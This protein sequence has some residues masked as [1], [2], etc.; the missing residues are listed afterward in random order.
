M[1]PFIKFCEERAGVT[2]DKMDNETYIYW[3]IVYE[4]EQK[5]NGGNETST[6]NRSNEPKCIRVSEHCE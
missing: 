1:V 2:P 4:N 3:R 5:E 6:R